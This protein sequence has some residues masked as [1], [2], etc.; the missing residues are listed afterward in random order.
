V[1]AVDHP[2]G[3]EPQAGVGLSAENSP[4]RVGGSQG[5]E[6]RVASGEGR[7]HRLE[8]YAAHDATMRG[9]LSAHAGHR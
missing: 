7:E 8:S 9:V 5:G 2:V 1:G 3:E 4:E 6:P